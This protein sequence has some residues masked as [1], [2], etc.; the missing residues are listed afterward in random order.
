MSERTVINCLVKITDRLPADENSGLLSHIFI[1]I[2]WFQCPLPGAHMEFHLYPRLF[3]TSTSSLN[4]GPSKR[5]A[6]RWGPAG[7]EEHSVRGPG[8]RQG[9]AGLAAS[10]R[11]GGPRGQRWRGKHP[12]SAGAVRWAAAEVCG[13]ETREQDLSTIY[14][15]RTHAWYL[16]GDLWNFIHGLNGEN[17]WK[18]WMLSIMHWNPVEVA[19]LFCVVTALCLF[20]FPLF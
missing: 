2:L 14:S 11:P 8:R 9:R 12:G 16:H 20:F 19:S 17:M 18:T 4:P 5:P 3:V 13:E 1:C 10:P 7:N 6:A 15:M